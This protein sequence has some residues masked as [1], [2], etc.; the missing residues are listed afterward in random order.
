MNPILPGAL[1]L[2]CFD[3]L[4]FFPATSAVFLLPA[5]LLKLD[6]DEGS[7]MAEKKM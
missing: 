6:E 5:P 7:I 1:R 3:P 2:L 4:P